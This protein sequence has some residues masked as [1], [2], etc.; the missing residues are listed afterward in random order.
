MERNES[1]PGLDD[2]KRQ[3]ANICVQI[4]LWARGGLKSS[5]NAS[6]QQHTCAFAFNSPLSAKHSLGKAPEASSAVRTGAKAILLLGDIPSFLSSAPRRWCSRTALVSAGLL[7]LTCSNRLF[8]FMSDKLALANP[9]SLSHFLPRSSPELY[10]LA[11]PLASS[12][13]VFSA[14]DTGQGLSLSLDPAPQPAEPA[15]VTTGAPRAAQRVLLP[16]FLPLTHIV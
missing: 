1:I 9:P 12:P 10:M 6:E 4:H 11:Q 8:I 3:N 5:R 13:G 14:E 2:P 15:A 16:L 7:P